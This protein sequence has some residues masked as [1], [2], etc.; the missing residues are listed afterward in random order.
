MTNLFLQAPA[1]QGM[2]WV[3]PVFMAAKN[4]NG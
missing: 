2:G 4:Q 3:T 1:G